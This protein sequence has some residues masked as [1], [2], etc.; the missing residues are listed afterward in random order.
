[1]L[2]AL[3]WLAVADAAGALPADDNQNAPVGIVEV[4]SGGNHGE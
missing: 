4:D 3:P 1:M 2:P